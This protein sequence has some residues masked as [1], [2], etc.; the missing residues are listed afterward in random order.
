MTWLK[1]VVHHHEA[2][3]MVHGVHG[4]QQTFASLATMDP[5]YDWKIETVNMV[6][7]GLRSSTDRSL[8]FIG[9]FIAVGEGVQRNHASL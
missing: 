1:H 9:G 6:L 7:F 5:A 3:T 8:M 4:V 2:T